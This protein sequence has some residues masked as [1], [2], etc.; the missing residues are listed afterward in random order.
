MEEEATALTGH[1]VGRCF[2]GDGWSEPTLIGNPGYGYVVA[3]YFDGKKLPVAF[4]QFAE[5]GTNIVRCDTPKT[6][7]KP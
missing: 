3:K 4:F 2:D 5:K 7:I 1:L 6:Y